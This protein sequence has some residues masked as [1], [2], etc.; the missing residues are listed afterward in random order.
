MQGFLLIHS[1]RRPSG[2]LGTVPS[3]GWGAIRWME[4]AVSYPS[5][6]QPVA[7][8]AP[9]TISFSRVQPFRN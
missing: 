4:Q 2:R 8:V 9:P 7:S 3:G 5:D 1:D 6:P